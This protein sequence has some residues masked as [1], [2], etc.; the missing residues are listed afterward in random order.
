MTKWKCERNSRGSASRANGNIMS[1]RIVQEGLQLINFDASP[2]SDAT[3]DPFR[4]D[5]GK[6]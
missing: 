2:D 6:N 3:A 1:E 5:G 4:N